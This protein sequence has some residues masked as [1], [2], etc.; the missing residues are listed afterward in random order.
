LASTALDVP[1]GPVIVWTLCGT[2]LAWYLAV[3]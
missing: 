1:T 2:G 3:K